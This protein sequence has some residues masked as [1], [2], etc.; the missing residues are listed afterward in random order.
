M[1]RLLDLRDGSVDLLLLGIV[2]RVVRAHLVKRSPEEL[3]FV[4]VSA[5]VQVVDLLRLCV[6][7]LGGQILIKLFL[8]SDQVPKRL[9][10]FLL[11]IKLVALTLDEFVLVFTRVKPLIFG[12]RQS[13]LLIHVKLVLREEIDEAGVVLWQLGHFDGLLVEVLLRVGPFC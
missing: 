2:I 9:N 13:I 3:A 7:L 4:L 11:A 12:P 6:G 5:A 10:L 1:V 8:L